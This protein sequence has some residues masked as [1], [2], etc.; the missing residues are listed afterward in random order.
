M[1]R[2]GQENAELAHILVVDDDRRIRAL[3]SRFLVNEGYRVSSAAN[4][5]EASSRLS[6]LIVDLVVLDVMMPGEDG[7]AFTMRLRAEF[8]S[9]LRR[10]DPD[11]HSPIRA[12]KPRRGSGGRRR[13]LSWQAFRAARARPAHCEH[14]A[15]HASAGARPAARQGRE[16]RRLQLQPR[17]RSSAARREA[18]T[19]HDTRARAARRARR[20]RCRIAAR[21]INAPRRGGVRTKEA[22]TS[23]L[24]AC[25]ARSTTR[26]I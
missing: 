12:Q 18:R 1:S 25:A 13:R 15:P 5:A 22:S 17:Q 11:A 4:A 21:A 23:R 24:R 14:P 8:L 9:A 10:A 16:F 7:V 20:R 19:A 6:E 26:R 3:L 2:S